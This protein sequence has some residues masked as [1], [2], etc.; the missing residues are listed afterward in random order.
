M[1][2]YDFIHSL[3][4]T[5]GLLIHSIQ[6]CHFSH[7]LMLWFPFD[8][9]RHGFDPDEF[10]WICPDV[11]HPKVM[12]WGGWNYWRLVSASADRVASGITAPVSKGRGW[13]RGVIDDVSIQI[14]K[15]ITL[16]SWH[17][18]MILT[19][20][21]NWLIDAILG[22]LLVI[23]IG[24]VMGLLLGVLMLFAILFCLRK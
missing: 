10:I 21:I 4:F 22:L 19:E 7:E 1:V 2:W 13:Q 9:I 12:E 23:G 3:T 17:W 20:M 6:W 8:C 24:V 18:L 16:L 15:L 14:S 11:V 5:G